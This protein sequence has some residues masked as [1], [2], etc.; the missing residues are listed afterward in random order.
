VLAGY[1]LYVLFTSDGPPV[2]KFA[3]SALALGFL[4]LFGATLRARLCT[5]PLDP[6]RKVRR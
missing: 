2:L 5:L 1:A 6:Y 3:L 4:A